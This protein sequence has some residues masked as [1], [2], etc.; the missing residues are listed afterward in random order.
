MR[1]IDRTA[2]AV[3]A[4]AQ[5][6]VTPRFRKPVFSTPVW[7]GLPKAAAG[8]PMLRLARRGNRSCPSPAPLTVLA[9]SPG[10]KVALEW[11]KAS[12]RP[13]REVCCCG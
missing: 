8:L 5:A 1:S 4:T 3:R 11:W 13:G 10:E 12:R 6:C 9:S 7:P 2:G